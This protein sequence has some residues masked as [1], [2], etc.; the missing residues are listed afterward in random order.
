MRSILITGCS[1]GI[2]WTCAHELH[3]GGWEVHATARKDE[4][5]ARL[6]D[7]GI[8]AHKLDYAEPETIAST[9]DAVVETT[10][11]TLDALFNNGAYGQPGAVEDLTTDVL[12]EQFEANF[13]GWHDLTNRV[14]P[15][16]RKQGHGRIVHCS[17]IL[18]WIPA[19]YRGAYNASKYALEGLASTM[20]LELAPT[21]IHVSLIEP[22]PIATR[23][24]EN[25]REKFLANIDWE[26]SANHEAYQ[27][28]IE[29]LNRQ[30][31]N[32]LTRFTLPPEA[33]Y[34]KLDHALNAKRPHAHYGVTVPTHV[35]NFA[36]RVLPQ[37]LVDRI[38]LS[39]A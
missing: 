34:R 28:E 23:F 17:S 2:G 18:G 11:G 33:V 20:R 32:T 1:S 5:I 39:G 38:I 6:R 10:G 36:R 8:F 4:D 19:P 9:F 22:G 14:V 26:S 24:S 35:M 21:G 25:A 27:S 7:K 29:R 30:R 3:K 31:K 16:M 12:R 15:I 37:R 13:F